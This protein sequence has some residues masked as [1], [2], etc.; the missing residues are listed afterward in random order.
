MAYLVEFPIGEGDTIT[1]E[2][3]DDQLAGF[4]PASVQ[5]GAIV[6]TATDSF[7]T[8]IDRLMPA[9]RAISDRLKRLAPDEIT[10]A[11]GV[12]VTAAAGV[13]VAKASGEANFTVTLKWSGEG[14]R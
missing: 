14:G 6:A 9:M 2:M 11:V 1:V 13:I 7:E 4:T 3:D 12:K 8:A 5:P 10:L